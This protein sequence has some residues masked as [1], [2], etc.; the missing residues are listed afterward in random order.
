MTGENPPVVADEPVKSLRNNQF[1]SKS[2]G[3]L[4]THLDEFREYSPNLAKKTER[5]QHVTSWVLEALG[6]QPI[7]LKKLSKC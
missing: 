3:N 7:E 2:S 6:S 4:P 5:C 1:K